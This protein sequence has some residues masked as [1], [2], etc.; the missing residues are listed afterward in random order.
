MAARSNHRWILYGSLASLPVAAWWLAMSIAPAERAAHTTNLKMHV[1][2]VVPT[3]SIFR[4]PVR[5]FNDGVAH[6]RVLIRD[7]QEQ[8]VTGARVHVDVV[9]PDGAVR[10]RVTA[11]TGADGCA[12]FSYQ[13]NA[14]ESGTV[15]TVR[16]ADV[17]HAG[18]SATY[19]RA[20]NTATTTSFSVNQRDRPQPAQSPA[21]PQSRPPRPL[22]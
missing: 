18:R 15:Y 6:W 11:L 13:L 12:R 21:A 19:D 22:R 9:A 5:A 16:V 10:A 4:E 14:P 17:V 2:E 3:D 8:P 1:V 7:A 20:S